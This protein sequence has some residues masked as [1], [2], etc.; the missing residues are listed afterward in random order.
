MS[1]PKVSDEANTELENP[2][3]K[4]ELYNAL[5]SMECGKAPG[6]DGIPVEFYKSLWPVLGDDLLEVINDSLT[7]GSLPTS[8][9]RAVITLLPKKGD[10]RN[11]KNWRPVSLLCSDIKILSKALAFRLREVIGGVIHIDQT[12]CVPNRSI[13]DNIHLIRDILD[14]SGSLGLDFGLISLDQEKAFDRVEHKYLWKTLSEFGFSP[15]FIKMIG[16]LYANIESILK[17]N[18]GLSV[19]FKITRGIRQGCALSGMLYALAIEPLLLRIRANIDGWSIPQSECKIK[20]SAYVDNIVVMIKNQEEVNTLQVILNEFGQLSSAKVNWC[21][22]EAIVGGKWEGRCL[23]KLPAGLEWKK[24]GF[25]YLWPKMSLRGHVTIINNLVASTFWH[26]LAC[27]EPPNGLLSKLQTVIVD[28]FWTKLH[29]IPQSVLYLPREEGGQGLIHMVSRGATFRLQFI[30]RLL[31]GPEDLVW[32]NVAVSILRRAGGLGLD[33][34]LFLMDSNRIPLNGLTPFY[35]GIFLWSFFEKRR[36]VSGSSLFWL[37]EE[38]TVFGARLDVSNEIAFGFENVMCTS[39]KVKLCDL[40]AE[41]GTDLNNSQGVASG[42]KL[43]SERLARKFLKVLKQRLTMEENFLLVRYGEGRISPNNKDPFPEVFF[44]PDLKGASGGMLENLEDSSIHKADRKKLYR[45]CVKVLNKKVLNG[46]VD[47]VWRD[48]FGLDQ[49]IKPVWRVLYKPPLGK[50]VGD[51]QWRILHGAVAVNAFI[52]VINPNVSN[53]C[54]F[55]KKR[56]TIFHCFME[57]SRLGYFFDFLKFLFN[58]LN[59]GF[60]VQSFILGYRYVAKKKKE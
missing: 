31:T 7:R 54:P 27:I 14:V 48:K 25:K 37:L 59:E 22:S 28:F 19:P 56:E 24:S 60:T 53:G 20:L 39:K 10:L 50:G 40:I 21:K 1:L 3:T 23:P 30:Q 35:K 16:V 36:V 13:F 6:I 5:K 44:S 55:C 42:L 47:T 17:I 8:C 29:W 12:Y 38:Q 58:S 52:S 26:R 43:K 9:R 18:G 46:R 34:S 15:G 11:I 32:R 4:G 41:G 45:N 51:L 2:F 33:F 49:S 57:C